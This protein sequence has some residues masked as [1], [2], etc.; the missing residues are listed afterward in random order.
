[1]CSFGERLVSAPGT[2]V[3]SPPDRTIEHGKGKALPAVVIEKDD[4]YVLN[5]CTRYL[6]R[7]IDEARH[8]FGQYAQGD[9]RA[10]ISEAWRYPVIDSYFNGDSI[11][12]SYKFNCVTFVYDGR[13]TPAADV[14]VTGS[15]MELYKSAPLRPVQFLGEPSGIWSLSVRIPKGQVHTY[16]LRVDQKWQLDPINPQET[17]LDN[18][19]AW[20]RFFTE[21][22]QIP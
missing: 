12:E 8:D 13:R 10:L 9:P 14:A 1:M 4:Q 21:S 17:I 16:K 11:E 5:H 15:F 2:G 7:D 18:G 3:V 6:A 22:C 20:S 19:K